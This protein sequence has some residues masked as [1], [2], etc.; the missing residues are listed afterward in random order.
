MIYELKDEIG[1]LGLA[2]EKKY[3]ELINVDSFL[4][5]TI[6]NKT[7]HQKEV[8]EDRVRLEKRDCETNMLCIFIGMISLTLDTNSL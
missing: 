7:L 8:D 6:M 1:E 4:V 3:N 5:E 2:I